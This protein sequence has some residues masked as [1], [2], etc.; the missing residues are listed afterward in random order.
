MQVI[1][2]EDMKNLGKAGDIVT[3]KDG[4][5][6]NYLLPRG[7]A[8]NATAKNMRALEHARR[9]VTERAK[10]LANDAQSLAQKLSQ[11][12]VSIKAKAGEEDRLFGSVTAIDI[13]EALKEKGLDIDKRKI[14]LDEPIKRL[15]S[16]VVS[17]KLHPEVIAQLKVEVERED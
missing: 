14:I 2:K 5:A 12:T 10:K 11:L 8:I 3:V 9:V 15:G 1:L 17:I 4:Y 13:S 6:R 7:I 16:H